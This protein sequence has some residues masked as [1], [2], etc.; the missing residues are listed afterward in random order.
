MNTFGTTFRLTTFGESH[1][2]AMGGVID[3]MPSG[4]RPDM[5][6]V[7]RLLD[8]RRTGTSRL[9]SQRRE[10]D[11]PEF[12]S[13]LSPDG[14]T[15]GTPLAFIVRNSDQRSSDYDALRHL[16][17]PNH[18]DFTY[19]ARY[20]LRDWR[21]GGRASARE[22]VSRVVAG[23]LAMQILCAYGVSIEAGLIRVGESRELPFLHAMI[24]CAP[25]RF[26]DVMP[27][28]M[29]AE[30]ER[31]R[32]DG[33]SVGGVV[34]CIVTGVPAG[35]GDPV[36][37][38]LQTR[39]AG[40]MM[41]INAVKG[42]DYGE[43]FEAACS[44]GSDHADPFST[45]QNGRICTLTNNSGGIQGGI[46]NGMP[47]YFRVAFKP[48]PSVSVPLSAVDDCGRPVQVSTHGRHDP[49]V[50]VRGVAVVKAMTAL[51]L[52]DMMLARFPYPAVQ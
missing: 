35:L 46:S 51:V 44:R 10:P 1:G 14:L 28:D 7:G 38:K 11:V 19:D 37:G 41:G 42:F 52:A 20:G 30:I 25:F 36:F 18:A 24:G 4:I 27:E 3:G 34:G 8:E 2:A 47:V 5:E 40:A 12:L 23:A 15:L 6:L 45:D 39:L 26:P 22:T 48:T 31:V 16:Y 13:G 50:A 17:R 33:D 49:C 32:A 29:V 9:V 21:G 43:G